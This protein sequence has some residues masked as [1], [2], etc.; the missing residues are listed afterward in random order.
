MLPRERRS[1]ALRHA[2]K[3]S[4][5]LN[6][7]ILVVP[8]DEVG[9]CARTIRMTEFTQ[10]PGDNWE[11]GACPTNLIARPEMVKDANLQAD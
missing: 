8:F 10:A 2:L 3:Q 6:R 9:E 1:D 11:R 4:N 5:M 7:P